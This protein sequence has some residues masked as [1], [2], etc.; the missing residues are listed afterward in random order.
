MLLLAGVGPFL[1]LRNYKSGQASQSCGIYRCIPRLEAATVVKALQAKG[2]TCK[3]EFNHRYC[4]LRIGLVHF[5]TTLQVAD[6]LITAIDAQI[7]RAGSVPVTDSGVAYLNW[8]AALPYA[9]DS[10]RSA[11]IQEWVAKQVNGGADVSTTVGDFEYRLTNPETYT[12]QLS[13]KGK[14]R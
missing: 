12:V 1:L 7:Y 11:R 2:H 13:I 9:M 8:F 4:D 14:V 10:G 6:G 5:G 3:E